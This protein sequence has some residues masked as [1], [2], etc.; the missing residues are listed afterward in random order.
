MKQYECVRSK[1]EDFIIESQK[2]L[3][4]I[5]NNSKKSKMGLWAKTAKGINDR[6]YTKLKNKM[7]DIQKMT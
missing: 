6:D 1:T 7:N 5:D 3:S 4:L 2:L